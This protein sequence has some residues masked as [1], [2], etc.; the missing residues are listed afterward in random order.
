MPP[1]QVKAR[2]NKDHLLSERSL[3]CN[4]SSVFV[5]AR[6][7]QTLIPDLKI[8][9]SSMGEFRVSRSILDS[10]IEDSECDGHRPRLSARHERNIVA[11]VRV[12]D[13]LEALLVRLDSCQIVLAREHKL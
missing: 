8:S 1:K 4:S 2:I 9:K 6:I 13:L 10:F 11:E 5:H 3:S 12:H 7:T